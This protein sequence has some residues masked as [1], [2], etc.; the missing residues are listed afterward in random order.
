[1]DWLNKKIPQIIMEVETVGGVS[2]EAKIFEVK[3]LH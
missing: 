3:A 2:G 1:M